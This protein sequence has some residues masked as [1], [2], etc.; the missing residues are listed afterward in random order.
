MFSDG[1]NKK[2]LGEVSI[3]RTSRTHI[4]RKCSANA[5]TNFLKRNLNLYELTEP[6]L[7]Q[8]V[9]YPFRYIY[10][11]F[12][13]IWVQT[14]YHRFSLGGLFQI[15]LRQINYNLKQPPI[16]KGKNP[17]TARRS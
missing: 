15:V 13:A 3:P 7:D 14:L 4:T 16:K 2:F 11:G 17:P 1:L 8:S 5:G 12:P 9:K 10:L 6:P